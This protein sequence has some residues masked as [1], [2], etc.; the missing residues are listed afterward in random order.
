MIASAYREGPV[1][2]DGRRYIKERHVDDEGNAYEFEW[3][4]GNE[5]VSLVLSARAA[6]LSDQIVSRRA[7]LAQVAGTLIPLTKLQFRQLF[8]QE[9][10]EGVD[11]FHLGFESH[12]ALD[13]AQKATIRTGLEDYKTAEN[14]A[15][16]FDARVLGMLGLYVAMGLLTPVRMTAIAG[17]GNG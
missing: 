2:A 17:L 4:A 13:D 3:L 15:R 14:I 1:Q 16:P 10:R 7:A 12:P 5:E 8:T 9:E 6:L 11:A